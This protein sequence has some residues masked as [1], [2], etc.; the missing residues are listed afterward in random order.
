MLLFYFV[1]WFARFFCFAKFLFFFFCSWTLFETAIWWIKCFEASKSERKYGTECGKI[2]ARYTKWT[3]KD[4]NRNCCRMA[5][6]WQYEGMYHTQTHRI[7]Y[8]RF[9]FYLIL[10]VCLVKI[11]MGNSYENKT[12]IWCELNLNYINCMQTAKLHLK[13]NIE[14]SDSKIYLLFDF[15]TNAWMKNSTVNIS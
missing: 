6:E 12:L 5:T 7:K 1:C 13:S 9:Y 2:S 10:I 15:K 11:E 8:F 3:I 4:T 14:P